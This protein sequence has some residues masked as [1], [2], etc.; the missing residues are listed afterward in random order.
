MFLRAGVT[1]PRSDTNFAPI[2][3]LEK[4]SGKLNFICGSADDLIP[5]EDR[6]EL[7]KGLKIGSISRD[8]VMSKLK[9][10]IMALC[11]RRDSFDKD[12]SLIGWNLLMKEFN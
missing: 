11:A 2:D 10:L 6:L 1:A 9:M 4:V 3:L 8:L 7:K 12:A 5:L